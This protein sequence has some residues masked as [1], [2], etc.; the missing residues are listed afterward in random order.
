MRKMIDRKLFTQP[1][2][3]PENRYTLMSVTV[4]PDGKFNMNGK[5]AEKLGGKRLCISFTADAKN[6]ILAEEPG[7]N[8]AIPFPK[9]GSKTIPS[10]LERIKNGKIPLPAKYE[11]WLGEDGIWQGDYAENPTSS[12]ADKHHSSKKH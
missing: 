7:S 8:L 5:L 3:P 6:F 1:V 12:P 10:A 4:Y 2:T 9:N 11:V